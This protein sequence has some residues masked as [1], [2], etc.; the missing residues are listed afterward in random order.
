MLS[1][2][3]MDLHD[4]V[5]TAPQALLMDVRE[6]WE[7][8]SATIRIPDAQALDIRMQDVPARLAELPRTQPIVCICHHGM[9]SAQVVA[10]LQRQGF[11]EVYNLSGGIDAWSLQVDPGV[12]RY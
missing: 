7:L 12:P 11:D 2:Q 1:L 9:R 6:P 10:F 8:Q 5:R 3:P 4:F